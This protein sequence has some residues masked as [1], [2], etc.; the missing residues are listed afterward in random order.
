VREGIKI[1]NDNQPA[2]ENTVHDPNDQISMYSPWGVNGICERRKE[3][4]GKFDAK[5]KNHSSRYGPQTLI[6]HLFPIKWIKDDVLSNETN[7]QLKDNQ[8]N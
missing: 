2:P 5:L 8:L 4:L 6:E 7:K 3:Q 1:N